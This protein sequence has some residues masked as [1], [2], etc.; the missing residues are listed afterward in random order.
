MKER[1]PAYALSWKGVVVGLPLLF[2]AALFL[3][4]AFWTFYLWSIFPEYNSERF[5][6]IQ[7]KNGLGRECSARMLNGAN[8][9]ETAIR[10]CFARGRPDQSLIFKGNSFGQEEAVFT[11]L[12]EGDGF[13]GE[14]YYYSYSTSE[15]YQC[16][17]TI[18]DR[19]EE[20][21]RHKIGDVDAYLPYPPTLLDRILIRGFGWMVRPLKNENAGH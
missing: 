6:W 7:K 8:P 11:Y 18:A 14:A 19:L 16:G 12:C 5:A 2:V 4:P 15:Y 1:R 20:I 21:P 17:Y 9:P 13:A 3:I 10:T